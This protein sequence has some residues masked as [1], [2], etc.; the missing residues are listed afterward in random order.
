MTKPLRNLKDKT[1]L[2]RLANAAISAGN[3]QTSIESA[4][5]SA[6]RCK[7]PACDMGVTHHLDLVAEFTRYMQNDLDEFGRLPGIGP[8]S[9]Q[10]I[11][12]HLLKMPVEDAERLASAISEAKAKGGKG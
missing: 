5:C 8:K 1:V 2:R 6:Y 12:F 4:A 11:A 9:A 10:R 7:T 3:W